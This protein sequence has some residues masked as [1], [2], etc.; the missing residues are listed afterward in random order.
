MGL[1]KRNVTQRNVPSNRSFRL[2]VR[3]STYSQHPSLREIAGGYLQTSNR[4]KRSHEQ[5]FDATYVATCV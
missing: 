5:E 1:R 2:S 4:D 3:K